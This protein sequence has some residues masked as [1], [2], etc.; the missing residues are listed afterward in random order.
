MPDHFP[1][2]ISLRL[3]ENGFVGVDIRAIVL[4][5]KTANC[6]MKDFVKLTDLHDSRF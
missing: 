2:V 1:L 3:G 4:K 5:K 6:R